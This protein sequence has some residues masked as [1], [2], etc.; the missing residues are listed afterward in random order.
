VAAVKAIAA[1]RR[2]SSLGTLRTPDGRQLALDWALLTGSVALAAASSSS[3]QWHPTGAVLALVALAIVAHLLKLDTR[4]VRISSTLTVLVVIMALFGPAPAVLGG[5]LSMLVDRAIHRT[6]AARWVL[7][8]LATFATLGIVGGLWFELVDDWLDH[9]HGGLL[10]AGIVAVSMLALTALNLLLIVV[11]L[12]IRHGTGIHRAFTVN[13][14][15]FIP[16]Q[17]TSAVIA[18]GLVLAY[19]QVGVAAVALLAGV[20]AVTAP[21]LRSVVVALQRAEDVSALQAAQDERAA[22]VARLASDRARLLDEMLDVAEHERRRL[23]EAL[24]D[25]PLQRLIALRHDIGERGESLADAAGDLDA[26]VRETRAVMA[27][28][29]PVASRELG[30]E[31]MLQ[32]AAAPFLHGRVS[33]D[34]AID[35]SRDRLQ[36]P[37]LCWVA[38]ELVTNAVKHARPTVV[39]VS[40]TADE[41]SVSAEVVDDGLGIDS[42]Q[43]A[44]AIHAGHVGLAVARRRVEDAGGMLE[45]RTVSTGGTHVHVFL[46]E[47]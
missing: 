14:L 9:D 7:A 31:A 5:C 47:A 1:Q 34:V 36:D 38:R 29:H 10:F 13:L 33:L 2:R 8:N 37:L 45:I 32:A 24:H 41:D 30:F 18:G 39:R 42:S 27:A 12:S 21:L 15:P 35:A 3:D 4:T 20:L 19:A 23:A 16:W 40:V 6:P 28:F 17:L 25:G 43:A 46:P 22:E 11:P 44:S 26:A